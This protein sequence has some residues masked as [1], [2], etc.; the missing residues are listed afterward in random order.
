MPEDNRAQ[1]QQQLRSRD[2]LTTKAA[3]EQLELTTRRGQP[4]NDQ[5]PNGRR[6]RGTR[7][8]DVARL[9]RRTRETADARKTNKANRGKLQELNKTPAET[10]SAPTGPETT[11]VQRDNGTGQQ[12]PP[13]TSGRTS[14]T[15]V[16]PPRAPTTNL[17]HLQERAPLHHSFGDSRLDENKP[18]GLSKSGDLSR[19]QLPR[20]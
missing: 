11:T 18:Q 12:V 20:S 16:V 5:L 2:Y 19:Q 15:Y 6:R 3:T 1:K 9:R 8:T 4:R 14:T 7:A 13:N 10:N 17:R